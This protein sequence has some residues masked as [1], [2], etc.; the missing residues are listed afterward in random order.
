M[1]AEFYIAMAINVTK[2]DPGAF[3]FQIYE[4]RQRFEAH[5]DCMQAIFKF[6]GY[7]HLF[8]DY[9]VLLRQNPNGYVY[10]ILDGDR[11]YTLACV[12]VSAEPEQ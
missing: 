12:K 7:R 1:L 8:E 10:V 3:P 6:D 4:L 5:D 11:E 2:D 9:D